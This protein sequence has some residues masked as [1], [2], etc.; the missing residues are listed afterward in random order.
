MVRLVNYTA[1]IVVASSLAWLLAAVTL[2]PRANYAGRTPAPPAAVVD[3][4]L[5]EVNLNDRDP[6]LDRY[7][8]WASGLARGDFGRT[9][10]GLSVGADLAERAGVTLRLVTAGLVAGALIGLIVGT[11]AAVHHRRWFDR[12]SGG[13][14]FVLLAV[15]AVV[16]ANVLILGA[17]WVNDTTGTRFLMVS[18]ESTTGGLLDGLGHLVLPALTLALPLA[19]VVSRYQRNT[20][21]DVLNADHVRT[22]RAKGLP[23]RTVIVKHAL[24]TALIPTSA[25]L[26]FTFGALLVGSTVTETVFGRHGLGQRLITAI[27]TGD[28]NTVAA[29]TTVAAVA[30]LLSAVAADVLQRVLNPG[31]AR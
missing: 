19:A 27:R 24:R 9:W 3:A 1:L 26:T 8:T 4:A 2:D 28:V 15:P 10:D 29:I 22:A 13:V 20:M 23:R 11:L 5:S 6:L 25:Y 12:L 30:L 17:I 16:L 18:G 7:L 14:V 31:R 21:L